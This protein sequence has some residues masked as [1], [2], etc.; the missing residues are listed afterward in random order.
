MR[1]VH[2]LFVGGACSAPGPA[3]DAH[4]RV[5][6]EAR[7][8]DVSRDASLVASPNIMASDCTTAQISVDDLSLAITPEVLPNDELRLAVAANGARTT[9]TMHDAQTVVI[10]TSGTT[11]L[12]LRPTVIHDDGDLRRAYERMARE[13]S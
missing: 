12:V 13:R 8:V 10:G 2:L 7:F 3:A 9:L 4:T 1:L 5:F 6:V 11:F